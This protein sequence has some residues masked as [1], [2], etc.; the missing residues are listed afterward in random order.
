MEI[1]KI[2]VPAQFNHEAVYFGEDTESGL[3]A[4]IAIH[5]TKL[6]PSIGGTRYKVYEDHDS[7]H[8]EM[9]L[10]LEDVLR[11]SEGM[12]FKN[13]AAKTGYGGAKAV[14]IGDPKNSSPLLWQRYGEMIN[15][16]NGSFI[17]AEDSGTTPE[18]MVELNRT[19]P[20]VS[21]LPTGNDDPSPK[22][23]L[24]VYLGLKAL[25][26]IAFPSRGL[27]DLRI[28]IEGVGNV[29]K[30]LIPF[31]VQEGA[32]IF[33]SDINPQS[34]TN[35]TEQYPEINVVDGILSLDPKISRFDVFIP[36]ALGKSLNSRSIP[37]IHAMGIKLV[38]GAA[39]NQLEDGERDGAT[40]KQF[41]IIY[42]PDFIINAGGLIDCV[43]GFI[44][45]DEKFVENQIKLIPERL[46]AIYKN[47]KDLNITTA[48]AANEMARSILNAAG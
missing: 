39:N 22:T 31:L 47:A 34:L 45:Y 27:A 29:G 10:A 4:I 30:A 21:G 48:S 11:L 25:V 14:I 36:C 37:I 8:S 23:A 15:Q 2:K 24:G 40:L 26:P 16:L 42:A 33:V 46:V 1:R 9:E 7:G 44:G 6:G 12:T 19:T 13:A 32:K 35:V 17:T 3:K 28:Y 18:M 38:A 43:S 41:G 5:S 20:Y